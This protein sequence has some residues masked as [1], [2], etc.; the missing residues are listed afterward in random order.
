MRGIDPPLVTYFFDG[1]D[2]TGVRSTFYRHFGHV[3][4]GNNAGSREKVRASPLRCNYET[5]RRVSIV[6]SSGASSDHK[7]GRRTLRSEPPNPGGDSTSL[8][9]AE[10]RAHAA[11]KILRGSRDGD[12]WCPLPE[13]WLVC[14]GLRRS[15]AR[16]PGTPHLLTGCGWRPAGTGLSSTNPGI[17]SQVKS[18]TG[19]R[20]GG[21]YGEFAR[22]LRR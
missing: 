12:R 2:G 7:T 15:T 8:G 4:A 22:F 3:C 20:D 1:Y 16:R 18:L 10:Y 19:Q 21:D 14:A 17:R 13:L 5:L 9:T 11:R 6:R